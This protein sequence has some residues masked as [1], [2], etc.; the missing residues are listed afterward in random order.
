MQGKVEDI[1]GINGNIM[2]TVQNIPLWII[3]SVTPLHFLLSFS[4]VLSLF[5][6]VQHGCRRKQSEKYGGR[7]EHGN[8]P[9][10]VQQH[11]IEKSSELKK[12]KIQQTKRNKLGPNSLLFMGKKKQAC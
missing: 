4:V 8:S 6:R 1:S 12:Q 5:S 11:T 7:E 10:S 2:N 3:I 9:T